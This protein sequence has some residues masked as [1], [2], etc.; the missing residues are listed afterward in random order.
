MT[1][2]E[3]SARITATTLLVSSLSL[4]RGSR[5]FTESSL[6]LATVIG[7]DCDVDASLGRW[8]LLLLQSVDAD[9]RQR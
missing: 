6:S 2:F 9:E 7:D 3:A 1:L 5:I 8:R 4:V